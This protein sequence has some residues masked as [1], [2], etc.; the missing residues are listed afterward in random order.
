V[1]HFRMD[2]LEIWMERFLR[3]MLAFVGYLRNTCR[4]DL[5]RQAVKTVGP[6]TAFS[7][8]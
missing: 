4:F 8:Q 6:L 5:G 1:W 7:L 3:D 2:D